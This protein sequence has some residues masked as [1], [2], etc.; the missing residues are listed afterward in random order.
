MSTRP[1]RST[2]EK[3]TNNRARRVTQQNLQDIADARVAPAGFWERV[4][5]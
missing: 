5:E 3:Y 1:I 4:G 2:Y